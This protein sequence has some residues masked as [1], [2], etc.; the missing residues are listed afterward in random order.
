MHAMSLTALLWILGTVVP[1]LHLLG[2]IFAIHAILRTRTSQGA[3]AWALSLIFFPYVSVLLYL[4]FGRQ[5]FHGYIEA[6]RRGGGI[7]D[8][9]AGQLRHALTASRAQL[10]PPY[11]R[12]GVFE[13]LAL[14]PFTQ[15]NSARLLIDGTATFDAIFAAIE[16][17]KDYV[18]IQFFI[19]R[20]DALGQKLQR[21]LIEKAS[22]GVK[23]Y[24][25]YD[26]IGC[27]L[28][29]NRYLAAL[30]NAGVLAKAFNTRR[31]WLNPFQIN[32]R[33]HRKIVIADGCTAFVGGHNV[34]I[35]Y[36]GESKRFGHWRDTHMQLSGPA[37]AAVH[38]SFVQD[39]HWATGEILPCP[40]ACPP[41]PVTPEEGRVIVIPTG[42]AV[43]VS[44]C[45]LMLLAAISAAKQR[46]WITSPYFVPDE[47]VYDALQLAALRGVDVRIMLP[48]RP[49]HL[50]VYLSSFSYLASGEAVGVKFYRY[51]AGFLHQKVF[52]VD[53]D[54]G[55]VGTAN[56]D[57]RSM[58]LNFEIT[59]LVAEKA[60]AA[61][62]ARMLEEDFAKCRS[63][64]AAE[65]GAR[66]RRNVVFRAAVQL[67]RLFSPIQ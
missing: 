45:S 17:A 25:L 54:L 43:D 3:I 6:K 7:L 48:A 49:D 57:N 24:F 2:G 56:L 16:A 22:Q 53:D 27:F 28:L 44:T 41:D 37:V 66:G 19:I 36:L 67:A 20:N 42:P 39:W 4:V 9:L 5:K 12:F 58:R 46:I 21:L 29:P 51:R 59:I 38:W 11:E 52:L 10:P 31:G 50:L 35:E 15:G 47:T 1:L 60:F 55:A 26:E 63:A 23:V 34:G 40:I 62:V 8:H 65:L 33:N 14:F 30:R 64:G 18:L 61:D 13:S 32:F